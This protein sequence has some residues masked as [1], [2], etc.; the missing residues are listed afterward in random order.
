MLVMIYIPLITKYSTEWSFVVIVILHLTDLGIN[1]VDFIVYLCYK[2][3]LR[4]G[5]IKVLS[6]IEAGS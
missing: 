6:L 2:L 3:K 4:T 1:E 5:V